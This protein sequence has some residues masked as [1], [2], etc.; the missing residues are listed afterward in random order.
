MF[1]KMNIKNK[2]NQFILNKKTYCFNDIAMELFS[3]HAKNNILYKKY[4]ELIG[5]SEEMVREIKH[6]PFLPIGFFKTHTINIKNSFECAFKSSGTVGIQRS[7]HF[8]FDKEIYQKSIQENFISFFGLIEEFQILALLPS[9]QEQKNSSLIY[10]VEF[11]R[12][13]S[14][15]TQESF[16]LKNPQELYKRLIKQKKEKQKTILFGVSYALLDF[17][18]QYKMDFSDLIII[19]TGGMKGRRKEMHRTEL[20]QQLKKAFN[21]QN[22]YSEYGMTELLSQAYSKKNGIYF[23]PHWMKVLIRNTENPFSVEKTGKGALNIIDFANMYSCPFIAVDD[24]GEVYNNGTFTV[25]GRFDN[26]EIRGCN[27]LVTE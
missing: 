21:V 16:Y 23:P 24:L 20:H 1:K 27:L 14:K 15:K 8:V 18:E 12:K 2:I 11:L 6:I 5:V 22:I 7:T 17:V 9:Y 19:E 10:M 25:E 13:N 4:I 26:S 3:F